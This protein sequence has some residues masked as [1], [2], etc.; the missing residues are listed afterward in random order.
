[1][2][3][4]MVVGIIALSVLMVL[5][6]CIATENEWTYLG[7]AG[8]TAQCVAVD[9]TNNQIIYAGALTGFWKTTD[10][11]VN[12]YQ[13]SP[14]SYPYAE[15]VVDPDIP[16]GI[17][18][19]WGWGS[20]SDGVYLSTDGGAT[21]DVSYWMYC[22][23]ALA[24]SAAN[25]DVLYAAAWN[26]N[27]PQPS[28][29][30]W[31][32]VNHGGDWYGEWLGEYSFR[33][34]AV[35]PSDEEIAYAGCEQG[36]LFKTVNGGQLWSELPILSLPV[37]SLGIDSF[38]PDKVFAAM[39][40][41]TFSDGVYRSTNGGSSWEVAAWFYKPNALAMEWRNPEVI[42]AGSRDAGV[43]RSLDGGV[44]WTEINE[45]LTGPDVQYLAV[46]PSD[47]RAVYAATVGGVFRYD[48]VPT[49]AITLDPD[50]PVV[51]PGGT[52]GFWLDL[53]NHTDDW[54]TFLLQAM[55]LLPNGTTLPY[56]TPRQITMPPSVCRS[57]HIARPVPY[58]VPP[59]DYRFRVWLGTP[60]QGVWDI[61]SFRV[62]VV[63]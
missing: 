38:Q 55:V 32:T 17:W 22:G 2:R 29:G 25:H 53:C 8:D 60:A 45:G 10:G 41:G 36:K 59:G 6:T 49:V 3:I 39:G 28:S 13:P 21:W 63:P 30:I 26:P 31:R 40:M 23:D 24:M 44:S 15:L 57:V 7:L 61:D 1:M 12:W 4:K 9:L 43:I 18:G 33:C 58:G 50:S 19:I 47:R 16:G 52:L 14:V 46:D 5:G 20:W 51:H 62:T 56:E 54:Q 34:L 37:L 27:P 48:W 35:H 42:Y 11:G